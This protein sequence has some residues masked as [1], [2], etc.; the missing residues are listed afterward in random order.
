[1]HTDQME[2][3]ADQSVTVTSTTARIDVLAK[4]KIVLQA[5]QSQITLD[6][7]NITIACPGTFTVKSATHEWLGG[8]S[9]AA[10]LLPLAASAAQL[11]Q[12]LTA[13]GDGSQSGA[14]ASGSKLA[15]QLHLP[16]S[17]MMPSAPANST[18]VNPEDL[19]FR[20]AYHDGEPVHGAPY[21]AKLADGSIKTGTLDD[22]GYAHIG[23]VKAGSVEMTVGEDVR[24][25]Q[26][27]KLPLC[28]EDDL[29]E[30][31]KG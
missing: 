14:A 6:G 7:A 30:W 17:L 23:G 20:Y 19:V 27:F 4:S 18:S 24:P 8:E 5:G 12:S 31:M 25:F 13:G 26:K 11:S 22:Q 21:W 9:Q 29:A 28:P 10:S 2:I 15:K 16:P 1:A 3:L